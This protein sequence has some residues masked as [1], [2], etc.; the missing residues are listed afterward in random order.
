MHSKRK[1]NLGE[2]KVATFLAENGYSVFKEFGDISKI[3][4]ITQ[5]NGK[6]LSIQ[7]KAITK[8]NG[9]YPFTTIKWGPNYKFR[10]TEKD[11]D[12]FAVYCIEDDKIAWIKSSEVTGEKYNLNL[13]AESVKNNQATNIQWLKD[14]TDLNRVL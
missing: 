4:L 6:L 2:L 7:V 3:D 1:G 13:R 8:K 14:Y 10:Y 11:C 12:I 5:I 9:A